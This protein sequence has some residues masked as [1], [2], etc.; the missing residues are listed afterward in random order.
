MKIHFISLGCPKNTVDTE[1]MLG[2]LRRG[3]HEL[4]SSPEE[5]DLV[6]VNTCGFIE[7]AKQ[8]SLD[9]IMETVRL[10]ETRQDLKILAT[11]CL[12]ERYRAELAAEI[13]EL[14]GLM[15]VNDIP[16][17]ESV[18]GKMNPAIA[19]GPKTRDGGPSGLFLYSAGSPRLRITPSHYAYVKISEGCQHRCTFCAIPA[20]RGPFRSRPAEDICSEVRRLLAEGVREIILIGQDTTAYGHDRNDK[21]GLPGLLESICSGESGF[22]LRIMY[23][24]PSGIDRRLLETMA[25]HAQICPYLDIPF[26][27]AHPDILRRM[28]R[29]GDGDNYLQLIE[30]AR[31]IIPEVAIRTS[32]IT[33]FPGE[34]PVHFRYLKEFAEAAR[35]DHL[36]VFAYSDEENT[37]ARRLPGK[38]PPA[39][40]QRRRNSLLRKQRTLLR[41]KYRPWKGSVHQVLVDGLSE[42][43]GPLIQA[44][45]VQQAPEVDGLVFIVKGE[46]DG[47]K[48]GDEVRVKLLRYLDYDFTAALLGRTP[49]SPARD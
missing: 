42:E 20:I 15:G 22:R 23:T 27:H 34:T 24:N 39:V 40:A 18:I 25:R 37:P 10:K 26:Q 21:A 8:E 17:I 38:V 41:E 7:A 30:M 5:A 33:G 6:A 29:P 48:P 46:L 11:G 2:I 31:R 19:P 28:G 12:A 1:V 35:F 4:V 16:Y 13:P 3:G 43:H 44:R 9:V 49:A 32:L 47:L 36:G 14:D 45:L